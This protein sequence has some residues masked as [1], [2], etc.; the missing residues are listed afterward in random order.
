MPPCVLSLLY[1]VIAALLLITALLDIGP[2]LGVGNDANAILTILAGLLFIILH[3]GL[4]WGWRNLGVFV[5]ITV[6]VSFCSEALGVATGW[7]FGHYHYTDLLGLKIL[8][9]PPLIQAGYVAMSYAS[10]VTARVILNRLGTPRGCGFIGV[11]LCG[12]LI[13]VSWDVAM[14]PYQST[15]SGDWIWE[16]GGP[17]FGVP[18][19]NYLGWFGTVF[20]F[21]LL[22]LAYETRHPLPAP[23]SSSRWFWSVP[24]FY[25][26]LLALGIIDVPLLYATLPNACPQNYAGSIPDLEV[27]LSLIGLFVMGTPV[28]LALTKLFSNNSEQTFPSKS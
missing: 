23:A 8:G 10:L 20:L 11:A 12:A 21:M 17:Y 6:A 13:M 22:Y 18:F 25:Y 28:A 14:D 27:T 5:A 3:G 9:V 19:H 1:F 16:Q 15:L 24:V 26:A 4:A 7:V 2:L